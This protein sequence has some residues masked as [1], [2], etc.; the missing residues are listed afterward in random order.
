MSSAAGAF[1]LGHFY[2]PVPDMED[3]LRREATIWPDQVPMP[4]GIDFNEASHLQVL[5][6]FFPRFFAE[7]DYPEFGEADS[8]L[9][10]FFTRNSQF[11]WLDAR[12]LFVLLRAWRPRRFVE[13]G[14]GYSSLLVGDVNRRFLEGSCHVTCIEPYPREF[15]KRPRSGI[16]EIRVEPVQ[17]TPTAVFESLEAGDVLFIDS[18]HVAK[19]GS[20][21]VHLFLNVIPALKPGVR[22]HVHDIFLPEDYPKSWVVDLGLHWNEQYLLQALLARNEHTYRVLFAANHAHRAFPKEVA[23]AIGREEKGGFGGASFWFEVLR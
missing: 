7:Y 14:S 6:D 19:I 11:S 17:Q 22:V 9:E 21:V 12:L 18:S 2:S 23:R 4:L 3:L 15:L 10:Y 5:Q 16:A 13:V 8:E 1:G 20:D